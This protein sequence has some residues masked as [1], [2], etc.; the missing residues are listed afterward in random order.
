MKISVAMPVFN[1]A[2]CIARAIDSL[3]A[4]TVPLHEIIVCDDGSTDGTAD[5]V[6][7]RYGD[8]VRVLRL[9]HRNASATRAVGFEQATGD[10]FAF[11]DA[12]DAWTPDKT[13]RQLAYIDRHPQVRL[14]GS[15]GIYEAADG[16]IRE[17]WMSDYFQPVDDVSGDLLPSMVDR[18][19]IL[20]S[21]V[22]VERRAYFEVGGLDPSVVYSHDWDLWLRILA[23]YPGAVMKERLVSYYSSPGA[24]SRNYLERYRDNI[25]LM[26]RIERGVLGA[27][28]AIQRRAG[29]R[30]ASLSF[31][32]GVMLMSAGQLPEARPYLKLAARR[33]PASRRALAA[34]GAVLPG[35]ALGGLGRVG[36]LK[37]GVQAAREAS[38]RFAPGGTTW[39]PA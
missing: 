5:L 27:R 30:A 2:W 13:E 29:D 10:W 22:M 26:R 34:A 37:A 39:G 11:I 16:V 17:S 12:D 32:L 33:G 15:D 20:L 35:W 4:Q 31:D 6:E 21:S 19:W 9:P 8:A 25:E 23:R 18:C 14:V 24:L 1:G 38:A 7:D 28:R 36:W 3:L